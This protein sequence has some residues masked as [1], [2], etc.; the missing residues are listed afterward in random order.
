MATLRI[1]CKL[2]R[3][4]HQYS[5]KNFPLILKGDVEIF[6]GSGRKKKS[7]GIQR[8]IIGFACK[9]CMG[10]YKR[11]SLI[12]RHNIKQK[13]GQRMDDA[14]REKMKKVSQNAVVDRIHRQAPKPKPTFWQKSKNLVNRIT[15]KGRGR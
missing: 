12:K 14:I 4:E 8:V 7:L 3:G 6:K 9:R 10:S 13:E 1:C 5:K 2:C 11:E 15:G